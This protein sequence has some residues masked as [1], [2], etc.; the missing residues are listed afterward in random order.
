MDT[1]L[2]NLRKSIL[3]NFPFSYHDNLLFYKPNNFDNIGFIKELAKEFQALHQHNI[4]TADIPISIT[5][6]PIRVTMHYKPDNLTGDVSISLSL[7]ESNLLLIIF[8]AF[9]FFFM[10][11][12]NLVFG[13]ASIVA[14]VLYYILNIHVSITAIKKSIIRISG[15]TYD[16]GEHELWEKQQEWM[17]NELLCP[18]C[19]EQ[20]NPYSYKCINCGIYFSNPKKQVD[21]SMANTTGTDN[22]KYQYRKNNEKNSS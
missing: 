4:I 2:K 3:Y 19:G 14:G 13:I 18:A 7:L 16:L 20:K 15:T 12:Q 11:H 1:N 8:L 5:R 22:V 9:G 21:N 6:M 17:K 10:F